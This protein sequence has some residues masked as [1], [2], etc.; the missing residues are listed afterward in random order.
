MMD[1]GGMMMGGMWLGMLLVAL[2][3]L[4]LIIGGVYLV[5]RAARGEGPRGGHQETSH[6]PSRSSAL[7]IL[8]ERFAR[9]EIDQEEF[10]QRRRT[11][12]S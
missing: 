3:F 7:T 8:E 10:E 4:A 6:N 12:G 2:L 1:G 5:V 9:G 11:L